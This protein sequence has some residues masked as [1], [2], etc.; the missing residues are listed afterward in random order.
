ME[1]INFPNLFLLAALFFLFVKRAD[2]IARIGHFQYMRGN[3]A[4]A[5]DWYSR[6]NKIGNMNDNNKIAYGFILLRNAYINEAAKFFQLVTMQAKKPQTKN[7][8]KSMLALVSW[9]RGDIGEAIESLEE[10]LESFKNTNIY[11]N[12][13]LLYVLRGEPNRALEFN[14]E[15]Y[16]YNDSDK[17]IID[18]LAE[19]YVLNGN[20]EKAKEMYEKL[21]TLEPH[22]PEAFFGYGKLLIKLGETDKGV[23][24]MRQAL[25][26]PFTFLS[27][28]TREKVEN[29]LDNM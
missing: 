28:L 24:I 1:Y 13:G 29:F 25:D 3:S 6:A 21:F 22:F 16:D 20:L 7:Q 11:Q 14:L 10:L 8:A 17:I 19:S 26:K 15:A 23:E 12:L 18:N 5:L 2:L 9:K 27:V 4:K